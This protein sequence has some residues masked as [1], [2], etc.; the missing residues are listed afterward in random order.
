MNDCVSKLCRDVERAARS[1]ERH[2]AELLR[3]E[4]SA[5]KLRLQ[6]VR[7]RERD[8]K[9]VAACVE[10]IVAGVERGT[11]ASLV[12]ELRGTPEQRG[13]AAAVERIVRALEVEAARD[14]AAVAGCV[15][16]LIMSG[17]VELFQDESSM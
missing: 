10:R 3:R 13:A 5:E 1:A 8:Q 17:A 14:A 15:G 16:R 2:A 7:R 12:R 9:A 4:T 6:A 11:A